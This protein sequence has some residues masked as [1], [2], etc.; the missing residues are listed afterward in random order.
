MEE[1]VEYI[2]TSAFRFLPKN[3]DSL[4]LIKIYYSILENTKEINLIKAQTHNLELSEDT[5]KKVKKLLETTLYTDA[6][7]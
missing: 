1:S 6:L 7:L 3:I 2:A 5:E 4:T